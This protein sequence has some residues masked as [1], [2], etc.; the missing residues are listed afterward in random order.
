MISP[1]AKHGHADANRLTDQIPAHTTI[2]L[3]LI[4]GDLAH[5]LDEL[6][7]KVA[8]RNLDRLGG[9]DGLDVASD[10]VGG[11]FVVL[12]RE[13]ASIGSIPVVLASSK[14]TRL[15]SL[16]HCLIQAKIF[17]IAPMSLPR[18]RTIIFSPEIIASRKVSEKSTSASR[19][20]FW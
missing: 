20:K 3:A 10:G 8:S 15:A 4:L 7:L 18:G 12:K 17:L 2:V 1:S 19:G 5:A 11:F 13:S 6:L 14:S 9:A 16:I